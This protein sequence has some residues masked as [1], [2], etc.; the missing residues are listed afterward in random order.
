VI[1]PAFDAE[2]TLPECLR[3][4][5]A[6][7][8]TGLEVIVVDDGS[9][10]R[11]REIAARFP[12]RLVAT[13]GR[14]GPAAARNLGAAAAT[15]DILFFIDADVM[16]RSDTIDRLIRRLAAGD[17]DAVCGVQSAEM[18]HRNLA[19][20]YKNLWIRWTYI[21]LTGDVPLFYTTAAAIRSSTF[22]Q[23]GGFDAAYTTPSL[24]DTAFGQALARR[25]VPVR[26]QPDLE[27]EH[28]KRYSL[29][30][31]LLTDIR[32]AAALVRLK[33]RHRGE[34]GRNNSSV[35]SGYIA[36][37][38]LAGLA[39]AMLPLAALIGRPSIAAASLAI[40]ALVLWLNREFLRTIRIHGGRRLAAASVGLLW[41]ELLV[42]SVGAG[43][44]LL[45]FTLGN[46]Y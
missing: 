38:P 43:F 11:T 36:S 21:R 25:G 30:G 5:F 39:T 15:G 8:Y 22:R 33:L 20:V 3:H 28:A 7:R 45:G 1:I 16:I 35:P 14:S 26:V 40:V 41:L 12:A 42:A 18:R 4:V 2:C 24:E 44:G 10:D 29:A 31:L 17:A 34:M 23:A 19:S 13:A 6:S 37:I 32:R 46:R 9:T 27:V